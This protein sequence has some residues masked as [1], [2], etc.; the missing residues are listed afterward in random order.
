MTKKK[1]LPA[2]LV[3]GHVWYIT[4]TQFNPANG[5]RV[6]FRKTFGLN[7][8]DNKKERVH[9]AEK[10]IERINK[11]LPAGWPFED[12]STDMMT[13]DK[14]L[15]LV[16]KVKLQSLKRN[17]RKSYKSIVGIFRTWCDGRGLLEYDVNDFSNKLAQSFMDTIMLERN[18]QGSTYNN[19]VRI[20][21]SIWNVLI[22]RE[23]VEVNPWNRI[24]RQKEREKIR[25]KFTP[26]ERAII[27]KY[28]QEKHQWMFYA[29]LLQYYCL[30]RP[31]E[32]RF[33]RF[34]Y[35]DLV[36]GIVILPGTITKNGKKRVVT[37]P[38]IILKYFRAQEFTKWPANYYVFGAKIRPHL[39][40]TVG[41][42]TFN[43]KHGVFLKELREAG[44][45]GDTTGL[46]F[47]S[48]KDTGITEMSEHVSL[49]NLRNQAGHS[50][51]N[52]TL[53][54]YR[55]DEVNRE[56]QGVRLDIF[57]SKIPPT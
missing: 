28:I 48:W 25:R 14:A 16:L 2:R 20:L 10:H 29:I 39:N 50:E 45:L 13:M 19:Y 44:K 33:L 27:A 49:L 42:N 4:Y 51:T 57:Q 17:T 12:V 54:Y 3:R 26:Q 36:K 6:R 7:Y 5:K 24:K 34:K 43:Y 52:T 40:Q 53:I 47:Y 38:T 41:Y 23:I 9:E 1:F 21:K 11:L 55:P 31:T 32:L 22:E 46:S 15:K 30:I 37:I 56:V 35:F 8:I 18:I